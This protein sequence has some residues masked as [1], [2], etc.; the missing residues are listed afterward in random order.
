MATGNRAQQPADGDE[1]SILSG[2]LAFHRDA[3]AAKCD[4]LTDGQL[5]ERAAEPST[6][7]LLGLWRN[8][9]EMEHA[10]G[11]WSLGSKADL[12]W[13]WGMRRPGPLRTAHLSHIALGHRC[14]HHT[15]MPSVNTATSPSNHQCV[16]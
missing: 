13:V 12:E 4:G 10:Y 16:R 1:R 9:A 6:L 15:S 11:V 8:M 7:S 3:L 2:W 14:H 5:V